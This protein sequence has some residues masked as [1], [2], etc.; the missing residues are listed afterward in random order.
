MYI[1]YHLDGKWCRSLTY[2]LIF[3]RGAGRLWDSLT[4]RSP[5]TLVAET[6][7]HRTFAWWVQ[8]IKKKVKC[9]IF[10]LQPRF[11]HSYWELCQ[12]GKMVLCSKP[13]SNLVRHGCGHISMAFRS[14]NSL[15]WHRRLLVIWPQSIYLESP[16]ATHLWALCSPA[17]LG[18]LPLSK[19]L[20]L[21]H[22]S[23]L[24]L[25]LLF[26]GSFSFIY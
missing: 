22:P 11:Q 26:L 3:Q 14:S 10:S 21:C 2:F 25:S 7:Y 23:V 16:P 15:I 13:H 20:M 24:S 19:S 8:M 6:C 5:S 17:L 1:K 12:S 4:T 9:I 18:N